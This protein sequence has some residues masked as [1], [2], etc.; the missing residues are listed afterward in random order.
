M[1]GLRVNLSESELI[2]VGDGPNV[3]VLACF[4]GCEVDHLPSSY[5][6]LPLGALCKSTTI[7]NPV[8]ERFHKRLAGWK[9]KL[10][11]RWGRLTLLRSTLCSLPIYF[12]SLFTI[13]ASIASRL[14]KI[15]RDF[16]WNS[17][18]NGNGLHWVNWN[19]V[20]RPK[21]LGG[22]GIRPLRDMNE[23]LKTKWLWR[24]AKEDSDM[25]KNGIK[26]K[27]GIDELGW[28]SKKRVLIL[29]GLGVENLS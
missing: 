15:M 17:N 10:L 23:A 2:P 25:W 5:L 20:C 22:L 13:P 6:G 27:Y 4:F 12:M 26:A 8:I 16:L 1:S 9:S 19:E 11:S 7:W 24:F 28:W 14:E 18:D 21:Q 29:T 3:H